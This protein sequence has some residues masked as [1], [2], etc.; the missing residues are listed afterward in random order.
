MS[1]LPFHTPSGDA[2]RRLVETMPRSAFETPIG[3]FESFYLWHL[4]LPG[5]KNGRAWSEAVTSTTD[6]VLHHIC[7]MGEDGAPTA[8]A[9]HALSRETSG[10]LRFIEIHPYS[11]QSV[12]LEQE[13]AALWAEPV[14][15]RVA[16]VRA[17]SMGVYLLM[18]GPGDPAE[19]PDP[20]DRVVVLHSIAHFPIACGTS[21]RGIVELMEALPERLPPAII[22]DD[23][24]EGPGA[25]APGGGGGGG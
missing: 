21:Y 23:E 15:H 12:F 8:A 3:V 16:M 5:W 2:V 13:L 7:H 22:W 14:D 11:L 25:P 19:P 20:T 24:E 1:I 9:G 18:I 17:G 10:G 4:D 6:V